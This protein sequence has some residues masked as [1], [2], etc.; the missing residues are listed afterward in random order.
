[1]TTEI[2]E[3]RA[4]EGFQERFLSCSADIIIGGAKAGVGKT[5]ALLLDPLRYMYNSKFGAVIFRRTSPMIRN[6]GGLWDTSMDIYPELSAVPKDSVLEWVFPSGA[7]MKFSH[8][9]HEKDKLN[10]QGAQVPWIGFDELTHFTESQF[11]YLLGRNRSASGVPPCVRATCNPDPDSWVAEFVEWFIDQKEDSPTHGLPIPERCGKLRYFTRDGNNIV[12]GNSK[13]EV[14]EKCPHLFDHVEGSPE[15]MVVSMTLLPGDIYENKELLSKNPQYLGNL[16]ALEESERF[17]LLGGNWKM[18]Q[19]G[20]A[21]GKYGKIAAI[22]K[23]FPPKQEDE[24]N[25]I[26][27]DV[28]RFGKDLAEIAVWEGERVVHL[29]IFTKSSTEDLFLKIE[30]LREQWSVSTDDVLVDQDGVGGGLVDRGDYH[31]FSNGASAMKDPAT[32][33]KENYK[34]LKTQCAYRF[35]EKLNVGNFGIDPENIWIDGENTTTLSLRGKNI[36]ILRDIKKQLRVIKR[37]KPD[38]EQ[39]KQINSKEEQKN[40]LSGRSPDHFDTFMM[41]SWFDLREEVDLEFIEM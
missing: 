14:I 5:F 25:K 20:M 7:R 12:W 13:K 9:E 19:D 6:E 21:L 22:F 35:F 32:G 17:Q 36:D 37:K 30:E 8:L 40:S 26:T 34:N 28:A 2:S 23:N 10:W 29:E 39:K 41:K 1:M 38:A 16:M 18:K 24:P 27:C 31:G 11:F 33:I 15:D 4:Q 3:I